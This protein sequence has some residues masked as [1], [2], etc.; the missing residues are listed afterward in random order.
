MS[1][2]LTNEIID[3]RLQSTTIKRVGTYVNAITKMEWECDTCGHHWF[4][5]PNTVSR[6]V[7]GCPSCNGGV[8]LTEEYIDSQLIG[9]NISRVD[10][11]MY[12][13]TLINWK[14]N[15]CNH[16]WK[17]S[18]NN[19]INSKT[20]C[21]ICSQKEAGVK[22]TL[23]SKPKVLKTLQSKKLSMTSQYTRVVDTHSFECDQCGYQFNAILS[24]V[25]NNPGNNCK[26][27]SGLLPLTNEIVDE[28]LKRRTDFV[29]RV[30][31]VVN[32]TTKITWRCEHGH[33]WKAVPD[34]VLN[35]GTGCPTCNNT[36]L[37]NDHFLKTNEANN[38]ALLYLLR[39]KPK[40]SG[41]SFLKIGV[42]KLTIKKRFTSSMY[43][44]F[45]IEEIHVIQ[46]SLRDCILTEKKVLVS[47][48][49]HQYFPTTRFDGRTECFIDTPEIEQRIR[50]LITSP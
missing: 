49:F 16:Q 10:P 21:P 31:N 5:V 35:A 41:Q 13:T 18:P 15:K 34:S 50:S 46:R 1:R 7:S 42:T 32:A 27:C 26:S 43:K 14:C 12:S 9:R 8:K 45:D 17:A 39:F 30:D 6:G 48:K 40:V 47:N 37:Y 4:A 19:V 33:E 38:P 24:S 29:Y 28:K 3:E 23:F 36:G 44:V 25:I 20:G 11:Y 22:K 2:K